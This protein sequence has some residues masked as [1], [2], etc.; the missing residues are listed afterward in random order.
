M[1]QE[2]VINLSL[3]DNTELAFVVLPSKES[4]GLYHE[5]LCNSELANR[6]DDW[7]PCDLQALLSLPSDENSECVSRIV[8]FVEKGQRVYDIC[9]ACLRAAA[10]MWITHGLTWVI[11]LNHSSL[12]LEWLRIRLNVSAIPGT[13]AGTQMLGHSWLLF[14]LFNVRQLG[15]RLRWVSPIMRVNDFCSTSV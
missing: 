13:G 15:W 2:Q 3:N 6:Q 4:N 8:T 9:A 1:G 10:C 12:A 5:Y 11:S 7:S 14:L